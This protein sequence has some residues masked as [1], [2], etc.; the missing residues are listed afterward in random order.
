MSALTGLLLFFAFEPLLAQT[1]AWRTLSGAPSNGQKQDDI[2]FLNPRLGWA[3]NGSGQISRTTNGGTSWQRQLTQSGT[4]FRCIGFQ[5][6]L[7]GFAGNIGPNYFPGVT[8]TNPLYRTDDGGATWAPVT[9]ISGPA[10]TGLCALQVVSPQVLVA[11]G[12]VG[13]PAHFLRSTDG[14]A[15]WTS[16]ELPD[17]LI[18]MITDVHFVSADTGY[19][20]GGTS[21]NIQVSRGA[22]L[23]TTD[24]G[25]TWV[26]VFN[27]TH[28][29]EMVWKATFPSRRAG[30]LTLLSYAPNAPERFLARSQDGGRSW[31][32]LP[33]VNN[34]NKAFGIGFATDSVGWIGTDT[35][36]GYQ[37]VDAGQT[38]RSVALGRYINKVR[39]LRDQATGRAIGGYAIGLNL[40]KLTVTPT[41]P[42][43]LPAVA[44]APAA[45][46][47]RLSVAPNPATRQLTL[48]YRL[49]RRQRVTLL[50]TDATGRTLA[51]ILTDA[52]RPAGDHTE[53]YTLPATLSNNVVW[54]TLR[55]EEG[56]DSTAVS[57][58]P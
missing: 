9:T 2:Y 41:A 45:N 46:P 53:A 19:V 56:R 43:G 4:Y 48:H 33:F 36:T 17:T 25:Q 3:V 57:V 7:R 31:T 18:Q 50:L 21:A 37:T 10:P 6:S 28:R 24:G 40:A 30:Y 55:A 58:Q 44:P 20:F 49:S 35:G 42:T 1:Y 54:F 29:F 39:I 32:E 52:V 22:V 26:S 11:A 27:S 14:G 38:W 15:N 34:G 13:S 23:R 8:D 16:R 51:T 12:R 5:D 47:F